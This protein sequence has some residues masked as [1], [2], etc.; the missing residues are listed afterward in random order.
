M[1]ERKK[2]VL[3]AKGVADITQW[4]AE[5][6]AGLEEGIC[7]VTALSP[8]TGILVAD[9]DPRAVEDLLEDLERLFPGRSSYTATVPPEETAASVKSS[10]LGPEKAVPVAKGALALGPRQRLLVVSCS[11]GGEREVAI[12]GIGPAR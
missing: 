3:P 5:H 8:G 9:G 10:V 12:K 2:F 11:G 1:T 6:A 4:A 7:L